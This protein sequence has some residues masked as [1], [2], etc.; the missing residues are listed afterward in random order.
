MDGE[1][2]QN[3]FEEKY[4]NLLGYSFEQ[5]LKNAPTSEQG[6]YDRLKELDDK[7]KATEEIYEG[8]SGDAKWELGEYREKLRN[9][10]QLI[11]ELFGLESQDE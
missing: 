9:E 10:F 11:E 3:L 4:Q 2:L 8:L 6:A 5:W 1:K 7:L